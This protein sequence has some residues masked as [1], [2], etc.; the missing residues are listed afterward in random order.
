MT[1]KNRKPA[2][3]S[4]PTLVTANEAL[5]FASGASTGMRQGVGKDKDDKTAQTSFKTLSGQVPSGDVRLTANI[6]ADLH[7][8]LKI[9]AANRRTSIGE[10]LEEIIEQNI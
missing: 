8:K 1:A 9:E 5:R 7:L 10:L 2:S 6:R 4:K 3:I